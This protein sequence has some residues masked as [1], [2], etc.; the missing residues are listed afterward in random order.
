MR[1]KI[2]PICV[3]TLA[4]SL[5][6]TSCIGK[7]ALTHKVLGWNHQISNKFVNEL[8]FVGFWILPIYE[9]SALADLLV[10]NSIEFWSGSNPIASTGQKFVDGQNARYLIAWDENGYTI[11]N[12]ADK[13]VTH[14][15]FDKDENSWSVATEEGDVTFLTFLDDSHVKLPAG[16]NTFKTVELS[17][18]GV[19]AYQQFVESKVGFFASR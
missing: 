15:C 18:D 14:L 17:M 2:I 6:C 12:E 4:C 13:S 16:N 3:F 10:I 8:V 11:T 7:F 9:I 19:F 1:K 5:F